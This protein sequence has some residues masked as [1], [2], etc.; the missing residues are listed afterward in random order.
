MRIFGGVARHRITP[1]SLIAESLKSLAVAGLRF[2]GVEETDPS[3]AGEGTRTLK[4][5]RN[6]PLI[7]RPGPTP[8]IPIKLSLWGV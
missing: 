6:I 4:N 1:L 5:V 7:L 8:G 2:G 3:F